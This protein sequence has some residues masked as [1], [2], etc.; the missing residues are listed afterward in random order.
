MIILI[1]KGNPA[2]F[3]AGF[4]YIADKIIFELIFRVR[5]YMNMLEIKEVKV[6]A[7]KK[8]YHCNSYTLVEQDCEEHNKKFPHKCSGT[9]KIGQPYLNINITDD[10]GEY[11]FRECLDCHKYCK[12]EKLLEV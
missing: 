8:E 7:A 12:A 9:I 5:D 4:F 2:A 3:T 11:T 1:R 6:K 10:N